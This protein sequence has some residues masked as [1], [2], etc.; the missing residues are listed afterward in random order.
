MRCKPGLKV[1]PKAEKQKWYIFVNGI[2]FSLDFFLYRHCERSE[3]ISIQFLLKH[4]S[5]GRPIHAGITTPS[6]A[7]KDWLIIFLR[8]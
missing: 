3:A 8:S 5:V 6:L 4:P 1:S 2:I 7:R